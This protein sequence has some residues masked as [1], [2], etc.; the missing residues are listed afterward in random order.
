VRTSAATRRPPAPSSAE[1]VKVQFLPD[2][3]DVFDPL[4]ILVVVVCY[5]LAAYGYLRDLRRS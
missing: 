2:P 3:L 1:A 4:A 5:P